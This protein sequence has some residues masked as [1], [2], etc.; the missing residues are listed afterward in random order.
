[1]KRIIT[2]VSLLALSLFSTA[3]AE[4]PSFGADME[5]ESRYI[6]RGRDFSK[7][8]VF[9]PDVW[10]NWG[11]LTL[12]TWL[13]LDMT[14]TLGQRGDVNEID[15]VL[16]YGYSFENISVGISYAMFAYPIGGEG[17]RDSEASLSLSSNFDIVNIEASANFNPY[18]SAFYFLPKVSAA[19]TF[20]DMITPSLTVSLGIGGDNFQTNFLKMDT[21]VDNKLNDLV[22]K[23]AVDVAFPGKLSFLTANATISYSKVV[24]D[25]AVDALKA[26]EKADGHE[27]E[28]NGYVFGGFTLS[29]E[30]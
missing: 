12:V 28:E 18:S 7:G 15:I 21:P 11:D 17:A 9:Q 5:I 23:V 13:N 20:A 25:D 24:N 10:M 2:F 30:F 4:A 16:D 14:D 26:Y 27:Y 3:A 6:F 29:A 8:A 19:Y 22:T 1:M